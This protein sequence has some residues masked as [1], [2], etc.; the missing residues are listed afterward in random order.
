MGLSP[1]PGL[2][3]IQGGMGMPG[4]APGM[5]PPNPAVLGAL[6]NRQM[7][8]TQGLA[9]QQAGLQRSDPSMVLQMLQGVNQ[10]LGLAFIM[11]FNE[12][13]NTANFVSQTMQ[14]LSRAIKEAQ[15]GAGISDVVGRTEQMQQRMGPPPLTFGP[16]M[17][18]PNLQ[19][20]GLPAAA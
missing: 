10:L 20:M 6:R 13:P 15:E 12:Q 19:G 8:P 5:P 16:A 3:L 17:G 18:S 4:G 14:R 2:S 1:N 7:N 9:Q 11:S